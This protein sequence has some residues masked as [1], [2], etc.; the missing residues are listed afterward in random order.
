MKEKEA[1]QIY[2]LSECQQITESLYA[3]IFLPLIL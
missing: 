2:L 3:Y 1:I